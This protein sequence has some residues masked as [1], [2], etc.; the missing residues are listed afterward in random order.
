MDLILWPREKT[1][2][3]KSNR[4][5]TIKDI[6]MTFKIPLR[7]HKAIQDYNRPQNTV[8]DSGRTKPNRTIFI[9][10]SIWNNFCLRTFSV[11]YG[12]FFAHDVTPRTRTTKK[13]NKKASFRTFEHALAVKNCMVFLKSCGFDVLSAAFFLQAVKAIWGLKRVC[14]KRAF[15]KDMPRLQNCK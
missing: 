10:C 4:Y 12:T 1:I 8:L 5:F 14:V 2:Q 3:I 13:E 6:K 15:H 9:F 11:R 7:G